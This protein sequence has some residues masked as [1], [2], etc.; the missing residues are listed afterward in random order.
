MM[1]SHLDEIMDYEYNL[2]TQR[3]DSSIDFEDFVPFEADIEKYL[4]TVNHC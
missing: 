2:Q 4:A 3:L 1:N